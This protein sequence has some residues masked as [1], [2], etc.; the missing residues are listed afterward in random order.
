LAVLEFR[1]AVGLGL[2]PADWVGDDGG[3]AGAEERVESRRRNALRFSAPCNTR[4]PYIEPVLRGMPGPGLPPRARRLVPDRVRP[5]P[6]GLYR[7]LI[8]PLSSSVAGTHGSLDKEGATKMTQSSILTAGIDISK[9]TLDVA[10]HGKTG[11]RRFD[12]TAVA[13]RCWR[14]RTKLCLVDYDLS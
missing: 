3:F 9:A 13:G 5:E 10:I 7:S 6:L 14:L 12:N 4:P 1:H 8:A 11:V 2:Y